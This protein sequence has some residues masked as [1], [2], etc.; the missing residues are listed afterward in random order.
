VSGSPQNQPTWEQFESTTWT[1]VDEM[2]A[3]FE[4]LADLEASAARIDELENG[5]GD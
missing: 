4:S 5:G 1:D 2:L 3:A